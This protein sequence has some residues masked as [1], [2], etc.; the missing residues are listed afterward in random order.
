MILRRMPFLV[1]RLRFRL[2]VSVS[3]ISAKSEF[4]KILLSGA[5]WIRSPESASNIQLPY[6]SSFCPEYYILFGTNFQYDSLL[7]ELVFPE[8]V[9]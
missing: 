1:N 4:T 5:S 9:F 8:K 7:L 3:A 2:I 6:N